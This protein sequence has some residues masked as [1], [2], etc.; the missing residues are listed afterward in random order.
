M[1]VSR[2]NSEAG[3]LRVADQRV[4]FAPL[5]IGGS[6]VDGASLCVAAWPLLLRHA[7]RQILGI[8]ADV[9]AAL[10]IAPDLP[11]GGR[12]RQLVLEPGLLR[13]TQDR[14]RGYV[15]LGVRLVRIVESDLGRRVAAA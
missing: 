2:D 12:T 14:L 4:D 3:D 10:R 15:L 5:E 11:G 9:G 7:W 8:G 6:I 1:A 13:C